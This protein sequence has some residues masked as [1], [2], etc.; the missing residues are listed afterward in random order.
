MFDPCRPSHM[1]KPK[2]SKRNPS[3]YY[4]PRTPK[5][6]NPDIPHS[7]VSAQRNPMKR[8]RALAMIKDRLTLSRDQ[9]AIKWNVSNRSVDRTL[10]WAKRAN[11]L[12][13]AEDR[14]LGKTLASAEA[15]MD[16]ALSQQ[17]VQTEHGGYTPG[18]GP[19]PAAVKVALEVFK[20]TGI[21]RKPGT[22][23][24][25][26]PVGDDSNDLQKHIQVLRAKAALDD[27]TIEGALIGDGIQTNPARLLAGDVFVAAGEPERA[28]E[29][30]RAGAVCPDGAA[31]AAPG[32]APGQPDDEARVDAAG[33]APVVPEQPES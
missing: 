21:L 22:K 10:S 11:L 23:S 27:A 24:P 6:S 15:V 3:P 31:A 14:I 17:M 16:A 9:V 20:G 28:A 13:Q 29:P 4:T 18:E 8:L 12:V 7:Y 33:R 2:R 1:P 25:A 19:S 26:N 32:E 30:D 5:L